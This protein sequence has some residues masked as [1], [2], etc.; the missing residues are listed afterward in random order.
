MNRRFNNLFCTL[1]ILATSLLS[2]CDNK[3]SG[4]TLSD[5]PSNTLS[6]TLSNSQTTL[7]NT[8]QLQ[9]ATTNAWHY[10]HTLAQQSL[11][12]AQ[13]LQQQINRLQQQPSEE[14]VTQVRQAWSTAHE[15]ILQMSPLFALGGIKP[16]LFKPLEDTYWMI[17]AWPIEP[18][19]LDSVEGY[20][21]SGIVNDIA[22]PVNAEAMQQQ[23]GFSSPWEAV[24]GLHAMEYLLWGEQGNRPASDFSAS[25]PTEQQRSHGL[26]GADLPNQRRMALLQLQANLLVEEL[27]RLEYRLQHPA[28]GLSSAYQSLPAGSQASL[29]QQSA[30]LLLEQL[31]LAE[32]V[33]LKQ[34]GLEEQEEQAPMHH[35]EFAHQQSRCARAILSSV[36]QLSLINSGSAQQSLLYWL[37]PTEQEQFGQ[38]LDTLIQ[39]L[40]PEST[41][42]L[43]SAEQERQLESLINLLMSNSAP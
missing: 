35:C 19:Y 41:Q 9:Q 11:Q 20:P 3:L 26:S 40:T 39:S 37:S 25:T 30:E 18:G 24:L 16:N 10:Q 4:N 13:Q 38:K 27:Q 34:E 23:H 33:A 12:A 17:D 5:T 7:A 15:Q 22:I 32:Q 28:S 6:N 2:G 31:L 42:T 1:T 21:H 43:F 8:G 36:Q 29:W 14:Q